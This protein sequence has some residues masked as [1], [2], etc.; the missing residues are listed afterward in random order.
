MFRTAEVKAFINW[1]LQSVIVAKW[2]FK[3]IKM[4]II[5]LTSQVKNHFS[6]GCFSKWCFVL[7]WEVILKGGG[8]WIDVSLMIKAV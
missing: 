7:N 8:R 5:T 3:Y 2:T 6:L 4:W 1:L